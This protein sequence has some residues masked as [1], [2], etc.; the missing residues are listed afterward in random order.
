VAWCVTSFFACTA[1]SVFVSDIFKLRNNIK[2]VKRVITP[3]ANGALQLRAASEVNATNNTIFPGS[4]VE[5]T[6]VP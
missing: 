2:I 3:S 5:V 4:F 6:V 1:M